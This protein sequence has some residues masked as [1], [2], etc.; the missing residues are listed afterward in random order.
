MA[1]EYNG[2]RGPENNGAGPSYWNQPGTGPLGNGASGWG[3]GNVAVRNGHSTGGLRPVDN[4]PPGLASL[5]DLM[6]AARQELDQLNREIEEIRLLIRSTNT[7]WDR[8][9]QRQ[10]QTS[11]RVREMETRLETFARQEIRTTYLASSEADMRVFMMQ[12][13]RDR[14]QDKLKAFERYLRSVQQVLNTLLQL[15]SARQKKGEVD[16]AIA[17]VAR[18][19]QTQEQLRQRIAQQLHDGPAQALANVVLSAEI[20]EQ[21]IDHDVGRTRS[22]LVSLKNAVSTTL[23]ETRKFIFDLRPM[24]LDDLGLF[25]TLK[26]YTQDL[27][28]KT[29]IQVT[30][31]S[32]G[33]EQRLPPAIEISLFRIAQEALSN[34]V[35]H[36]KA[37]QA[38]VSLQVHE[39][40]VTLTIED[41]GQGFDVDQVMH[42][43]QARPT[44]GL[45]SMYERAEMLKTRLKIESIPGRGTRVELT[46]PR[47][48]T[49][50]LPIL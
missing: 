4:E 19:V 23:R 43:A 35:N 24:T 36:A 16:P 31:A 39:Q 44:V 42:A 29:G 30:F 33:T 9:K 22:E 12:E 41:D 45:T 1:A 17:H 34:V 15:Q 27:M 50:G 6:N 5:D 40:G 3:N 26:R 20:C 14:L 28:Q 10:A 48:G 46:V 47:Q 25:P 37:R 7:E 18:I 2:P 49:D 11:A 38:I 21:T 13:Q 8:A 32:H